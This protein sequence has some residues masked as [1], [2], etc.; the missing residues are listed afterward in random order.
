MK[1][2]VATHNGGFHADDTFAVATLELLLGEVRVVRTRDE[3][4]IASADYV[5]DV[6]GE[7]NPLRKRFDHH[8]IGGAGFHATG[9][10]YAAFGLVWKEYGEKITGSKE[11]ADKIEERFSTPIDAYDNDIELEKSMYTDFRTFSIKKYFQSFLPPYNPTQEEIDATFL[12]CVVIARELLERKIAFY[13]FLVSEEEE[14]EKIYQAQEDK[15]ILILDRYFDWGN[16]ATK[17]GDISIVVYP[18][19]SKTLWR[20]KVVRKNIHSIEPKAS[21]PK[22]WAGKTG[23]D[24]EKASGVSGATFCHNALFTV[25]AKTKEAALTMSKIALQ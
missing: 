8:Q 13:K 1:P 23:E 5:V 19:P 14:L 12:K 20:A 4:I 24:L 9:I 22:E 6:G 16:F 21:F 3:A 11:V 15:K 7:Y 2:L 25:S 10:P 17:K 18:D